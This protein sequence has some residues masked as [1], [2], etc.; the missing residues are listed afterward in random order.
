VQ[1]ELGVVAYLR[2]YLETALQHF[3]WAA[4]LGGEVP[5]SFQKAVEKELHEAKAGARLRQ[6]IGP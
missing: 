5:S 1:A 4:L 6:P 2:R 3:R